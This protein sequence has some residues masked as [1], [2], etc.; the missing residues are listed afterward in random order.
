MTDKLNELRS[1]ANLMENGPIYFD[2]KKPML[3]ISQRLKTS[4]EIISRCHQIL[5]ENELDNQ[6]ELFFYL[7]GITENVFFQEI[8]AKCLDQ[9]KEY[10]FNG[11]MNT[12]D[13]QKFT[14]AFYMLCKSNFD[15]A[16]FNR[17]NLVNLNYKTDSRFD[18]NFV[19]LNLSGI[20]YET[21]QVSTCFAKF[22]FCEI[23]QLE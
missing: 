23:L 11:S 19:F 16:S 5:S 20:Q 14:K 21:S 17:S 9:K 4:D 10:L 15:L 7:D 22:N 2:P 1:I 6:K 3:Q 13:H 8:L 18:C 12:E